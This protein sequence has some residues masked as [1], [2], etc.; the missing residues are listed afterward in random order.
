M[1]TRV[2]DFDYDERELAPVPYAVHRVRLEF[3]RAKDREA[4]F[5]VIRAFLASQPD[6]PERL[7]AIRLAADLLDLPPETQAGLVPPRAGI[8]NAGVVSP[9]L[10]DAGHRLERTALAGVASHPH[11]IR[12]LRELGQEHF[13]LEL[14]RRARVHL[15]GESPA[16]EELTAFLAELYALA[17]EEAIGEETAEQSLLRLRER[18]L[19][20]ELAEAK[21]DRVVDLQQAL[22]QIRTAIRDFA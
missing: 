20:R 5:S 9:R 17:D 1:R 8:P 18:R 21:D 7:D 22:L 12:V 3:E 10:L 16:N 19:Q 2:N 6:S 4:A 11:L 14:H 15:L 13:D